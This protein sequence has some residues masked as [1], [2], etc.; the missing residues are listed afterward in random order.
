[1][2]DGADTL[3]AHHRASFEAFTQSRAEPDRRAWQGLEAILREAFPIKGFDEV[4]ELSYLRYRFGDLSDDPRTCLLDGT[5]WARTLWLTLRC[6]RH[7]AE[8]SGE[9]VIVDMIEE[10]VSCGELPWMTDEGTFVI[11]GVERVVLPQ[12]AREPGVWFSRDDRD[13]TARIEPLRGPRVELRVERKR[14]RLQ[15]RVGPKGRWIPATVLPRALGLTREALLRKAYGVETLRIDAGGVE[16]RYDPARLLGRR[17]SRDVAV[18]GTVLVRRGRKFT[19]AALRALVAA[20]VT[21][22]RL[23]DSDVEGIVVASDVI[24][25]ETGEVIV[26]VGEAASPRHL[27]RIRAAGVVEVPVLVVA[28]GCLPEVY[29]GL[30]VDADG[31]ILDTELASGVGDVDDACLA[32]WRSARPGEEVD[33]RS[34]REFAP[35]LLSDASR[36]DLTPAGRARMNRLLGTE[37]DARALTA[38]DLVATLVGF[39]RRAR[40]AVR[41]RDDAHLSNAVVR[42]VGELL[43]EV[44]RKGLERVSIATR[45]RLSL[46]PDDF[47]PLPSEMFDARRFEKLVR[48][49]LTRARVAVAVDRANP[50]ATVAQGRWLAAVEPDAN[51]SKRSGFALEDTAWSQL[52]LLCPIEA[53]R[54]RGPVGSSLPLDARISDRGALE[55]RFRMVTEEVGEARYVDALSLATAPV[56]ACDEPADAP[57]V[58]VITEAGAA[59]GERSSVG[60]QSAST[61]GWVGAVAALV[62]FA[63]HDEASSWIA[64]VRNIREAVAPLRGRAPRVRTTLDAAVARSSGACV[65][66]TTAGTVVRVD[67]RSVVIRGDEGETERA[68]RSFEVSRGSVFRERPCVREGEVVSAGTII[69]EGVGVEGRTLACGDDALVALMPW[70]GFNDGGAVV[71][72]ERLVREGRLA[73]AHVQVVTATVGRAH[74]GTHA[75]SRDA[76]DLTAVER[77][78]LD[79]DALVRVGAH[80]SE[81]SALAG[82]VRRGARGAAVVGDSLRAPRGCEGVVIRAEMYRPERRPT[83]TS[84]VRVWVARRRALSVGDLVGSRHGDRGAVAKVVAEEDLPMLPDGRAVEAVLNPAAVVERGAMGLV[85]ELRAGGGASPIDGSL[86]VSFADRFGGDDEPV[87]LRDGRTGEPFAARVCVGPLHL[88]KLAPLVDEVFEARSR[89]PRDLTTR[90]PVGDARH[91]PGQLFEEDAAWALVAYGAAHTLRETLGARGDDPR[92]AEAIAR[93]V[94]RGDDA[95]VEAAS[96]TFGAFLKTLQ[97][98]AIEVTAPRR[99]AR[100]TL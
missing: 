10:E 93:A 62:P 61:E 13:L 26:E 38:D 65:R 58:T 9:R 23:N 78:G 92:A 70:A 29:F 16:L 17:A 67:G 68:L 76:D 60:W 57:I 64:G 4:F 43:G 86:T 63:M 73:T 79:D 56:S 6:V 18:G 84:V 69:A 28:R 87:T 32:L 19:R 27:A 49:F 8:P 36:F 51:S 39:V 2:V 35:R 46:C 7:R 20:G 82:R 45:E 81:G 98:A 55:G 100:F 12:L 44:A 94:E 71:V 3:L 74:A 31:T 11:H 53:Q 66:A 42:S 89:G 96:Q 80:V 41:D 50:A 14:R 21:A 30:V 33:P 91:A 22:L 59:P 99:R 52:G 25:E 48:E 40:G 75:L 90:Q 15:A 5:T 95:P 83:G 54:E 85:C 24:D 1:M 77:A 47:T 37:G 34:A 72:S 97:A 88:F